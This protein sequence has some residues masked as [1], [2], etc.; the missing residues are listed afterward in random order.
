MRLTHLGHACLLVETADTRIL[1]DPGTFSSGFEDLTDLDAVLVTHQ[2]PDHLDQERL[3]A[4]LTANPQA[5]L[6]VEPDA[7][8]AAEFTPGAA[9]AAGSE[10][11]VGEVTI[12]GVGGQ[13]AIIH[14]YVQ[15]IGNVGY[16]LSA[17][18]EPTLFHPGDMYA[19]TPPDVDVL[20]VPINA[21]WAKISE[22]LA[23]AR[24]IRPRLAVPIHDGLVQ[25]VGR[26]MYVNHLANFSHDET[27]VLD[28]A[29]GDPTTIS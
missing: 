25:P 6:F 16:V 29:G 12:R 3:P 22:T 4:M 20:A 5:R 14:E 28:L 8:V 11:Q 26:T 23:F 15:P 18:G 24:A 13:H 10:A 27:E 19:A 1:I 21:P 2:H 17:S 9:F 7:T